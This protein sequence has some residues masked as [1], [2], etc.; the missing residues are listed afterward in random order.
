MCFA[1]SE[2]YKIQQG[3]LKDFHV[4]RLSAAERGGN[5]IN[6]IHQRFQIN[7]RTMSVIECILKLIQKFIR[8]INQ[9]NTKILIKGAFSVGYKNKFSSDKE[10]M[11]K[12]PI[13]LD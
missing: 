5:E 2:N 6:A 13:L 9:Q 12:K 1:N 4:K 10:K 3:K 7:S 8:G 11:C